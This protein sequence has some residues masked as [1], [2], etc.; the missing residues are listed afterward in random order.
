MKIQSTNPATEELNKEFETL[1]KEQVIRIC[2]DSKKAFTRWKSLDINERADYLRKLAGLLSKRK[3]E[4]GK[5]ITI[6]MGKPIKQSLSEIEK[7]AWIAEVYSENGEKWLEEEL[8]QADGKKHVIT[9]EPLGTI[10]SI[11]PWNFPFLQAL[12]FGIPALTAGNVSVLRHS[13]VV[14]MCALA[15]EQAFIEAG[16]PENIF[17]TIITNHEIVASLI[18][19]D[20]INGVSFTGSVAAGSR[21]GQLAGKNIKKFVLELGG[22]DPFIVL[23]DADIQFTCKNAAQGRLI[24]SGQSCIAAKRFIVIKEVADEFTEKFV[25]STEALKVGNPLNPDTD[26]GPLVNKQQ[27]EL[28]EIQ[29]KDAVD[30]GAKV[31]TGGQKIQGKGFFFEP[32]I[33]S[34]VKK[35]M[36]VLKEE[37][38]GPVA[39]IIVVRNEKEAINAANS[40][41]LGLGASVWSK[42]EERAMKIARTLEA[43]IVFIN[44]IVKSDPRLPFGGVKKSGIGREL[45]HYGIK[46]F[47]NVKTINAY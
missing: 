45:S 19:N 18:K 11:M 33:L 22:S 26:V 6:E 2:K 9:F 1:S 4:Y 42:N 13:N 40:S 41:K 34:N 15:I 46:E 14:P 44:G 3:D 12:R 37:V 24:N 28:L 7:C 25:E 39:P 21:V 23:D 29:I 32:T 17:R 43:G 27:L 16:F 10:L 8:V 31:L 35:S 30:K 38:F 20:L 36:S 5:L 47:V